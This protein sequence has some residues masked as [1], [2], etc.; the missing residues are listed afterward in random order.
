MIHVLNLQDTGCQCN[1]YRLLIYRIRINLQDMYQFTGY[2]SIYRIPINYRIH[3]IN[4]HSTGSLFTGYKFLIHR[5]QVVNVQET[6][7]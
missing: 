4:S 2:V 6:G 1:G 5:I 7:C 3:I